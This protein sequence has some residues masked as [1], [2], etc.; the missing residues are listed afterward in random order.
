MK[1][2]VSAW[3]K[4]AWL[5]SYVSRTLCHWFLSVCLIANANIVKDNRV[6]AI[7][8]HSQSNPADLILASTQSTDTE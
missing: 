8:H 7:L 3:F 1:S 2:L 4:W 6:Q 5:H